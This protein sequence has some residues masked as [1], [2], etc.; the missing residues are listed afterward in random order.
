MKHI[1]PCRLGL[2]HEPSY[3]WPSGLLPRAAYLPIMHSAVKLTLLHLLA[4]INCMFSSVKHSCLVQICACLCC[5]EPAIP[6][7]VHKCVTS[8]SMVFP[9]LATSLVIAGIVAG[10]SA[11]NNLAAHKG[12]NFHHPSSGRCLMY[13]II[14]YLV[15]RGQILLRS[16]RLPSCSPAVATRAAGRCHQKSA[17]YRPALFHTMHAFRISCNGRYFCFCLPC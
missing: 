14:D 2:S 16:E 12:S 17:I 15:D 10:L 3:N 8:S 5:L 6:M 1:L 11:S 13:T 9:Q 7:P 4:L